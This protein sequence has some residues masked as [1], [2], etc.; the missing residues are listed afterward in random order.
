MARNKKPSIYSDRANIGSAEDLDEY[1]VW[2]KGEPQILSTDE[3]TDLTSELDDFSLPAADDSSGDDLAIGD[4][5][6]DVDDA[7][8][9]SKSEKVEFPDDNVELDIDDNPLTSQTDLADLNIPSDDELGT[10][11]ATENIEIE[12]ASFDEFDVPSMSDETETTEEFSGETADSDALKTDEFDSGA[13]D[14][15]VATN[16]EFEAEDLNLPTV[17][18]I[19]NNITAIEDDLD[20]VQTGDGGL[21]TQLLK[22]IATELSS[23]RSELTDLKREFANIRSMPQEEE[24]HA[25]GGGF[26]S[27][28]DDEAISLTGDEL[29]NILSTGGTMEEGVPET[30]DDEEDEVIALT[31][32]ELDNI[33][34]SADFTEE[35]GTEETPESEFPI[36][37]APVSEA[38]PEDAGSDNDD[39]SI[40]ITLPDETTETN[41][42]AD[43]LPDLPEETAID[44]LALTDTTADV[45]PDLPEGDTATEDTSLAVDDFADFPES[46]VTDISIDD[47]LTLPESDTA[48]EDTPLAADDLAL[49]ESDIATEDAPLAADD[50]ALPESDIATEDAP[51]A[52]DDL[53]LPESDT[54]TEDAPL[55]ADDL[56][57][58]SDSDMAIEDPLVMDDFP[59][60]AD[61]GAAIEDVSLAT[62]DLALPE[63]DT[64]TEDVSLAADDLA[65]P[66][67]DTAA[68]DVFL[69]A[70][71]LALPESDTAAEDTPLAAD[72]LPDLS[73]SDM[74]IETPI[75]D[76]LPDLSEVD[77]GI[78]TTLDADNFPDLT[79]GGTATEDV[80]LATDDFADF[81]GGETLSVD[82]PAKSDVLDKLREEG[83][84]IPITETPENSS[85]LE[86]A[87]DDSIDLSDAVIDEPELSTEGINDELT[88]PTLDGEDFDLDSLDDLSIDSEMNL[89]GDLSSSVD[90]ESTDKEEVEPAQE[91]PEDSLDTESVEKAVDNVISESNFEEELEEPVVFDDFQDFS[92]D[93]FDNI[94]DTEPEPPAKAPKQP[95]APAPAPA[96]QQ[97]PA[98]PQ[99][100]PQAAPPIIM[101]A[102]PAPA[103][104][105][106]QFSIP[107]GLRS[108]LRNI[109]SYMDQLLESLPEEK[110]EEF[111]K[112]DYFDS[113]KKLFKDLG[114]V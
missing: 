71:D 44:D 30:I 98:A 7:T 40:D 50:L 61:D 13:T 65:L 18:S 85:Y 27:D 24:K 53:A 108:E 48:I 38:A 58:L 89:D 109:L 72:D 91:I 28:D 21:S 26:F 92:A 112:S 78:N 99:P 77:T 45:L 46:D 84:P 9:P 15:A 31:G 41:F 52:A 81:S 39:I 25:E 14:S 16:D 55:A 34:N 100:A 29:N 88:E 33:V 23:I 96:Q 47:E 35:S 10:P 49:P 42:A 56:S 111:A 54:A 80:S 17:K 8:G 2:V 64:V 86:E 69:D 12:D 95:A 94:V 36:D 5:A 1:G 20:A 4:A 101:Q 113:Y 67:S 70:D 106:D 6:F 3:K 83:A 104:G 103:A 97:A 60:L 11:T 102:P 76:D 74:A 22:K 79:E 82:E 73:D 114:L 57:D 110:I 19:E 32:D 66:E 51:L 105:K 75:A 87:S 63:S 107:S 93:H 90:I 62:D 37:E 59:D 68:E 43:A